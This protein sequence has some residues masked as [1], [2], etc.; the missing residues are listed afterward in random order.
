MIENEKRERIP[1]DLWDIGLAFWWGA[2]PSAFGLLMLLA[3]YTVRHNDEVRSALIES[4]QKALPALRKALPSLSGVA[5]DVGCQTVQKRRHTRR[6]RH[7]QETSY[8]RW[9]TENRTYCLLDIP[10]VARQ[11]S[12]T[13]W[14]VTCPRR[15][16]ASWSAT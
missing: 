16:V 4:A 10:V 1:F 5:S 13:R 8:P 14:R 11:P 9:K 12:S 7:R 15:P 6:R 2:M 3:Q